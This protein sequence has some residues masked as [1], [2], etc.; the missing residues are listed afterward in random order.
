MKENNIALVTE[1][2]NG[3]GK[4]FASI[5]IAH[6]YHVILAACE[7]SY[8]RLSA[9]GDHPR[10]YELIEMDFTSEDRMAELYHKL[11]SSWGKLDLLVNNAEIVNGFGQKIAQISIE[12]VRKL[13]EINL[14]AVIKA[15]QVLKPLLEKSDHPAIINITSSLGDISKMTKEEFCYAGYGLTAYATS[16]AALNMFT[17]LQCKEFKPSKIRIHSFDPV[18]RENCTHNSVVICGG[19]QDEFVSLLSKDRHCKI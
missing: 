11:M 12:D 13:Y 19:K 10:E 14:F 15:V 7:E 16:K 4:A 8:Q 6:N 5:L 3:L 9:E 2:G 1:A 17:Q 18:V